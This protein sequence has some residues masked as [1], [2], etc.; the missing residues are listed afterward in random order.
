[1]GDR[2]DAVAKRQSTM[3]SLSAAPIPTKMLRTQTAGAA[4]GR[5][6]FTSAARSRENSSEI[7]E[8]TTLRAAPVTTGW[9][10]TAA[11]IEPTLLPLFAQ[12][13]G[14]IVRLFF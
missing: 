14:K 9:G 1:M 2:R 8:V 12:E 13:I 7:A 11:F 4:G 5:H 3:P 6:E 10:A